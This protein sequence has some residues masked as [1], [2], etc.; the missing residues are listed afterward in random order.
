MQQLQR[1][2]TVPEL[3][4]PPRR[5]QEIMSSLRPDVRKM[6]PSEPL[7]FRLPLDNTRVNVSYATS[8]DRQRT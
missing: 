2:P 5:L 6:K 1:Q 7:R 8:P 3:W 4:S